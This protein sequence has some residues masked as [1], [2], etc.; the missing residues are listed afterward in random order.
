MK[1]KILSPVLMLWLAAALA[2]NLYSQKSNFDPYNLSIEH[3][4]KPE[5]KDKQ[6]FTEEGITYKII[7]TDYQKGVKI[8]DPKTGE[9]WHGIVYT[10]SS[11]KITEKATYKNGLRHGEYQSLNSDGKIIFKRQY[12]NGKIEGTDYQYHSNGWLYCKTEYVGGM[13][14]GETKIYHSPE[15]GEEI[16]PVSSTSNYKDDKPVGETVGYYRNGKVY[17]RRMN[18]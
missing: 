13:K 15:K 9:K 3:F 11:G 1:N 2:S 6:T 4:N 5:V 14:N 16:G 7:N 17:Y 12:E 18:K 8:V 10:L